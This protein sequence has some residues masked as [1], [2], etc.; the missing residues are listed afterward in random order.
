[1]DRS[2]VALLVDPVS[3]APLSL[4]VEQEGPAG[5]ILAGSLRNS[6]GDRYAIR[7]GIARF[8]AVEDAGQR[9]TQNAFGFKWRRR[10]SYESPA[11]LG[12]ARRWLVKRYG[13]GDVA[14]MQDFF[15][16]RRRVLDA[17]CGSG[18]STGLWLTP[19]W[20][21]R[22]STQVIGADVS[23]AIDV[24][25]E[26]VGET[27]LTQFVQSDLMSLPFADAFD[28]IISEGVLHHT[29]ST[30]RAL[31]RLAGHLCAGG[32]LMFYVYSQKAPVREFT[33]DFVRDR[34]AGL[35]PEDAWEAL[36]PL[37]RLGQALAALKTEVDVPEDVALLGIRAGRYDI[38]RLLYWNFAKM[39]WNDEL[40]FEEN[41]HINFDWYAPRYAHRHTEEEIRRW[42]GDLGLSVIH[43][44]REE[45]GFTVR[46]IK[47]VTG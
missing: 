14:A 4:D 33:D 16:T 38:Q 13:F 15:A 43:F 11:M 7:N 31:R 23:D 32:E 19:D 1:M 10:D 18:F 2:L 35:S 45:S 25:R 40:S 29:P 37:T 36:R 26:R 8:V 42:C 24:A 44:D 47:Q 6:D 27:P 17:G 20:R 41:H 22:V 34:I 21:A 12:A 30:E 28:A 39:F 46:A 9:Q 3:A 5:E